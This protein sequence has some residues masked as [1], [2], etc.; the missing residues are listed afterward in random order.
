MKISID[1]EDVYGDDN[2][3]IAEIIRSAI[4][5]EIAKE[6]RGWVRSTVMLQ[7]DQLKKLV[8]DAAG[9]DWKKVAEALKAIQ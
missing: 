6:I 4:R 2:E 5:E 9:R 1:L 3:T 8:E 7:Q